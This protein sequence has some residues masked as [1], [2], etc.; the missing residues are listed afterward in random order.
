MKQDKKKKHPV[1]LQWLESNY[2]SRCNT[3]ESV[4]IT[5][6]REKVTCYKCLRRMA[7][8]VAVFAYLARGYSDSQGQVFFAGVRGVIGELQAHKGELYDPDKSHT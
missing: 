4:D 5:T 8:D 6:N 3:Y 1:H 2:R 7:K